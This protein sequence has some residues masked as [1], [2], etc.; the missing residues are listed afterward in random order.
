LRIY[1][2]A[3][4]NSILN[5]AHTNGGSGANFTNTVFT[6]IASSLLTLGT[7][8]FTGNFKPAGNLSVVCSVT[9]NI[10]NFSEIGAGDINPNGTWMLKVF[11]QGSNGLS[12]ILNNWTISIL[13][14]DV[15]SIT[16]TNNYLPKWKYGNLTGTSNLFDDGI[17]IGIGTTIPTS[18]ANYTS[19]SINNPMTGSVLDLMTN[20]I[21]KMRLACTSSSAVVETNTGVPLVFSPAATEAMRISTTGNVGI[22]TT[23]PTALSNYTTL[24]I[25]HPVNGAVLD[26]Q[27]NNIFK[28][29]LACT[30][31]SAVIETNSGVPLVF[32]PASTEAMRISTVGNV[33]I[34]TSSPTSLSNYTT[35][36][37]NNSINGSVLDLM[38]NNLYK[39]RLACTSSS[40]VVETNTEVPLIFSPAG[41]E[42]MRIASGGNV[43]IGTTISTSSA[44]LEVASNNKGF[45]PPRLTVAQRNGIVN[46]VAG[47]QIWCIDCNQLQVYD[48]NVWQNISKIKTNLSSVSITGQ[49]W[50]NK[51]LDVAAYKN[52]DPIPNVTDPVAWSIL[53]TGAYCYY[54]NDSATYAA[55]YGKLYNWYAVNDPRGLAPEGW[56]IPSKEEWEILI[57]YCSGPSGAGGVL[58][59]TS[60][61]N[62]PNTGATNTFVFSGLPGGLRNSSGTFNSIGTNSYWWC[63]TQGLFGNNGI[64]FGFTYNGAGINTSDTGFDNGYSIRCIKD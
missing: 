62:S 54:N 19:L 13:G 52:G 11:D 21:Y 4:N 32:S 64:H 44:Q 33:G 9:P 25:N 29:R 42:A 6:D 16:V 53:I 27:T 2:I 46:P 22:G 40:A 28:M 23:I 50:S 1:L 43:S 10:A 17:N 7:V 5:L 34:G 26:L 49:I 3:P 51:N 55:L 39:L 57:D 20:N 48:G 59:S 35:L 12:G 24:S 15:S 61:W 36:S 37:I 58:K 18:L 63:S 47:L 30:S 41:A 45:L 31:S 8:P 38:T 14:A 56:H 60:N